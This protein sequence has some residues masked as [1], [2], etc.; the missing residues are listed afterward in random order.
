MADGIRFSLE[1]LAQIK[2]TLKL[3]PLKL[4][5]RVIRRALRDGAEIFKNQIIINAPVLT[6]ATASNI[7][8]SIRKLRGDPT[9]LVA[10]A[11]TGREQF[12]AKFVEFGTERLPAKSFMRAAFEGR[13]KA[14]Q[15]KIAEGIR[16][17]VKREVK[18]LA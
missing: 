16:A 17:G 10:L 8:I 14:V 1:N 7:S 6:G 2:R 18:R 12:Y 5:L 11:G 9:V 13:V 4:R 15:S 3:L